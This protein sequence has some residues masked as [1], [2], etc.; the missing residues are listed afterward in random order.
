MPRP[1]TPAPQADRWRGPCHEA[2]HEDRTRI[3]RHLPA[4]F[5]RGSV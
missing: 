4:A 3:K 5:G 1:Q 2:I